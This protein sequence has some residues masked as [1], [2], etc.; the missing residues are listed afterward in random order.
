[1]DARRATPV[2]TDACFPASSRD[3]AVA[4][5]AGLRVG[6]VPYDALRPA[7]EGA[8]DTRRSRRD[9]A[10]GGD[11]P[12]AAWLAGPA[13][14]RD[15]DTLRSTAPAAAAS[16]RRRAAAPAAAAAPRRIF[17]GDTVRDAGAASVMRRDATGA[18][19]G[20]I[21]G[22]AT[23]ALLP[24]EL[25]QRF[26]SASPSTSSSSFSSGTVSLHVVDILAT[27]T[28]RS[29]L[30]RPPSTRSSTSASGSGA[31]CSFERM[32]GA[33]PRDSVGLP[34][35]S[36][37]AV[38]MPAGGTVATDD[39]GT[40]SSRGVVPR[41]LTRSRPRSHVRSFPLPSSLSRRP[42]IRP[43]IPPP[44]GVLCAVFSFTSDPDCAA[45]LESGDPSTEPVGAPPTGAVCERSSGI[46]GGDNTPADAG[47]VGGMNVGGFGG[48]AAATGLSLTSQA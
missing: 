37:P 42:L 2:P 28:V 3:A 45:W 6:P 17:G 43:Q 33:A 4:L 30:T 35:S 8:M 39:V 31:V 7:A 27:S 40:G 13:P 46:A 48:L 21:S 1:M 15:A 32:P 34:T 23:D 38:I 5:P 11:T 18:T 9:P 19:I 14:R 20:R 16:A 22:A 26:S 12:R 25:L 29:P 10:F 44:R 41:P 36:C 47:R 24:V